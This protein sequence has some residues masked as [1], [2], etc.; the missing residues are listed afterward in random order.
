MLEVFLQLL[1][2]GM[3]Y[4]LGSDFTFSFLLSDKSAPSLWGWS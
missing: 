1:S 2:Y 4:C 3:F